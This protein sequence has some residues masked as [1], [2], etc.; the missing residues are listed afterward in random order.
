MEEQFLIFICYLKVFHF[1]VN[2]TWINSRSQVFE[3][4]ADFI[5]SKFLHSHDLLQDTCWN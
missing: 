5:D 1:G 3:N 2:K 4:I